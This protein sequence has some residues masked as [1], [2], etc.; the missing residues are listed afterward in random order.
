MEV[1]KS[2]N[3][4]ELTQEEMTALVDKL[5]SMGYEIRITSKQELVFQEAEKLGM[6]RAYLC[7]DLS[8][9]IYSIAD[10]I[11]DNYTF[12]VAKNGSGKHFRNNGVS[13]KI[14]NEYRR[15]VSAMLEALKPYYG[16]SGFREQMRRRSTQ[17]N[18][19]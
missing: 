10:W 19:E 17:E 18:D 7:A 11:T 5:R 1:R 3:A 12:K 4:A 2:I 6:G 14:E 13:P 16:K 15:V 8:E 9:H